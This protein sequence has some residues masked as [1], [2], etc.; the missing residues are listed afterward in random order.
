MLSGVCVASSDPNR[1]L[2]PWDRSSPSPHSFVIRTSYPPWPLN[3]SA[4]LTPLILLPLAPQLISDLLVACDYHCCDILDRIPAVAGVSEEDLRSAIWTYRSGVNS[5]HDA[6]ENH[7]SWWKQFEADLD[8]ASVMYWRPFSLPLAK[9]NTSESLIVASSSNLASATK[10][11]S[12]GCQQI[13]T[14]FSKVSSEEAAA[15]TAATTATSLN[16]YRHGERKSASATASKV[17]NA[18]SIK[19]FFA[20][21]SQGEAE[22]D[23]A[24]ALASS[25]VKRGRAVSRGTPSGIAKFFVVE[26]GSCGAEGNSG[27]VIV[28]ED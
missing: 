3:E 22:E 23:T 26:G 24:A 27:E 19:T 13:K 4:E 21:I 20:N 6:R 14:F 10:A 12:V 28:I 18:P 1:L 7:P 11:P 2:W 16:E 17:P 25:A 9:T 5:R 8:A 15:D